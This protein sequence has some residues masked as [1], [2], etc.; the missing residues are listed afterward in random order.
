MLA[1]IHPE[2]VHMERAAPGYTGDPQAAIASLFTSDVR[3]V[4]ENGVIGDPAHSSAEHGA[5]YWDTVLAVALA[6]IEQP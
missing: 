1:A 3:S 4:S 5:R 6:E 2:L